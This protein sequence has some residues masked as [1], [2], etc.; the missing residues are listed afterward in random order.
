M[1]KKGKN[2]PFYNKHHSK[3]TKEKISKKLGKKVLCVETMI[4]YN[5]TREVER[6]IGAHHENISACCRGE[7]KMCNGYHWKYVEGEIY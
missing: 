4:L 7:I 3:E 5:S 1:G 6:I 2:H